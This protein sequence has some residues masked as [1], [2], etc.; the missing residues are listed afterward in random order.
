M[1]NIEESCARLQQLI[2]SSIQDS[3]KILSMDLESRLY[4]LNHSI[5]FKRF[6]GVGAGVTPVFDGFGHILL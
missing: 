5:T 1:S 3:A 4:V 6:T 2:F